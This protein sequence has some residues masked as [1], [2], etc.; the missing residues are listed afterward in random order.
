MTRSSG[1]STFFMARIIAGDGKL[2]AAVKAKEPCLAT[3][4][5]SVA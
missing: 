3:E 5:R 4:I 1:N 2:S